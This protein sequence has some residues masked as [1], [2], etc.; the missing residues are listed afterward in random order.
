MWIGNVAIARLL[1]G[2]G[3]QPDLKIKS[4]MFEGMSPRSISLEHGPKD[5]EELFLEA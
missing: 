1:L 3:A 4:G 2:K 5:I